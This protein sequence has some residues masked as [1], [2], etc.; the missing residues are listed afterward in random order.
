MIFFHFTHNQCLPNKHGIDGTG[1]L[2]SN[3]V[4][5]LCYVID[6]HSKHPNSAILVSNFHKFILGKKEEFKNLINDENVIKE[7]LQNLIKEFYKSQYRQLIPAAMSICLIIFSPEKLYSV[8]L[9]DCRLGLI[10]EKK[11]KWLTYP[12]NL[13]MCRIVDIGILDL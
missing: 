11:L 8:H 5:E 12:H 9:G 6:G 2:K 4:L 3:P 1:E 7:F 10:S 13:T